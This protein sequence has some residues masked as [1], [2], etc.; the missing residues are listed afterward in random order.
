M[1]RIEFTATLIAAVVLGAA[2]CGGGADGG[3]GQQ[4][5][6]TAG[7]VVVDGGLTIPEAMATDAEGTIAVQGFL[8]AEGGDPRLCEVLAESIP[9]QC[10]GAHLEL[11]VPDGNVVELLSVDHGLRNA[12]GATWSDQSITLLGE[13]DGQTFT[14]DPHAR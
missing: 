10:G 11:R 3:D 13:L 12:E 1:W 14:I 5:A 4:G 2:G 8:V 7:G 6:V 9:P